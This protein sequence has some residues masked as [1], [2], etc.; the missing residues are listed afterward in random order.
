VKGISAPVRIVALVGMLGALAMGGWMYTQGATGGAAGQDASPLAPVAEAQAVAGKLNAHNLATAAGK[1][2]TVAVTAAAA[3]PKA[4][5]AAATPAVVPVTK[6]KVKVTPV[7]PATPAAKPVTR[8]AAVRHVAKLPN[9]T[10]HTIA[11]QLATHGVVV[12]LLYNPRAKVD[13]YS[14]SEAA[15]GASQAS[16]GFLTVDVLDQRQA[17]P[18]TTAYGVLQDPT[19]LFFVRP[20]K[21]V[22]KLIGFAD[23]ET[24]SQA[25][26]NEAAKVGWVPSRA[27][28]KAS[29]AATVAATPTLASWRTKAIVVCK[30]GHG[31]MQPLPASPSDAELNASISAIHQ[32]MDPLIAGLSALPLPSAASTRALI[33]D[34]ISSLKNVRRDYES[35]FAARLKHDPVTTKARGGVL[36][37]EVSKA[38][39]LEKQLG[40]PECG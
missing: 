26:A 20:G 24:V 17:S 25:A 18:F 29:V 21:L 19:I 5:A 36:Q 11:S 27:Q 38:T 30:A 34:Y 3:K 13:S 32:E 28:R 2:D 37:H 14:V 6:P 35:F 4:A 12:V 39:A 23:H 33:G 16:A 15:L 31:L 40:L 1:P 9:G 10:P 22:Q 8:P 7:A